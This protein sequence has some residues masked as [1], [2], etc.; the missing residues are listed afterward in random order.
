MLPQAQTARGETW[1]LLLIMLGGLACVLDA[2]TTWAALHFSSGFHE[3]TALTAGLIASMGLIAGLAVSV[4]AR[5]AAFALVAVAVERIPRISRPL[6][7]L[8][9]TAAAVTWLIVLTNIVALA[10]LQ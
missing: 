1:P 4:L 3:G 9:F 10:A 5:L 6:L 2:F 7:A 8:G